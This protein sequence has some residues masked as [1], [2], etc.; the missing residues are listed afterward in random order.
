[1]WGL[2]LNYNFL[3]EAV[4]KTI[5]V[6]LLA[7]LLK[8]QKYVRMKISSLF[9]KTVLMIVIPA[10]LSASCN[11]DNLFSLEELEIIN[12]GNPKDLMRV[13]TIDNK[14]DSLLLRT[15]SKPISKET[16]ERTDFKVLLERL[17]LTV[18]NPTNEGVGIAAPQ[19][20]I[21]RRIIA[22]Q[23][24]DKEGEPFDFFINPEII[25]YSENKEEGEEGCLS[26][27]GVTGKVSRSQNII[28][29]YNDSETF[30]QREETIDGFTAV[31]VQHEVDH[32]N[33]I[34]F[35]DYLK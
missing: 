5:S 23:R 1:M 7:I 4:L 35:I 21:L 8:N 12:S 16:Y 24:F 33:G 17:L 19:V 29:K 10:F 26:I 2:S 30:E 11:N 32:L 9:R 31:I 27:P 13:C 34:L 20:G 3:I 25:S 28:L 6:L 18:K 14:A 15:S 22:V